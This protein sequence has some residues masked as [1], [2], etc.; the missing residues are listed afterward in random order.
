MSPEEHG[1]GKII[2][3]PQESKKPGKDFETAVFRHARGERKPPGICAKSPTPPE[4]Q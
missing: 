1:E 4:E 2:E 3:I